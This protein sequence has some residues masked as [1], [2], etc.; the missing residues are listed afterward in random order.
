MHV[1]KVRFDEVFDIVAPTGYFSFRSAGRTHYGVRLRE[2]CIPAA[3]ATFAVAFSEKGNWNSVLGW[4]AIDS[5]E[6]MLA[7][8]AAL[9]WLT[10]LT[11]AP[12]GGLF[13]IACGLLLGGVALG[14]ARSNRTVK[15]ALLD[16]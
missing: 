12:A 3:G 14:Q 4:R 13:G 9:T 15:Q 11:E 16:V 6:V 5:Y 2:R 8:P 7:H 1:E 10:A